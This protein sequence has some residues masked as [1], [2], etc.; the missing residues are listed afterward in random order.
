MLTI[1]PQT[2][3]VI[4]QSPTDT[5]HGSDSILPRDPKIHNP[6]MN[7]GP[8]WGLAPKVFIIESYHQFTM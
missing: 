6:L 1:V 4:P 2:M 3:E 8:R 5:K 7:S